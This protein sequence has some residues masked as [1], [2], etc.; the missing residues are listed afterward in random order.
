MLKTTG[1]WL[2]W[3]KQALRLIDPDGMEA[4]VLMAHCT[5]R[6]RA[7]L[8]AR[9]DMVL[10]A[11]VAGQYVADVEARAEG[12]PVAYITGSREFWSLEFE[13]SESVLIPRHETELVVERAL[14]HLANQARGRAQVVDLGTGSGVIA[15]AVASECESCE[16]VAV[17]RSRSA[18]R[19]ARRNQKRL[20]LS[21]VRFIQ[22]S[23]FEAFDE[24]ETRFDLVLSNPPYIDARDDHLQRGD[25][26]FEPVSALVAAD[27][28][29]AD[30]R[31]IIT[32]GKQYLGAGGWMVLEHGHTQ[33][34]VIQDCF[35]KSG[36]ESII[37]HRDL[38]GNSRVTEARRPA[39]SV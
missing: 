32:Q 5:G 31:A 2:S 22:G 1:E 21:N 35:L 26:R 29:L 39:I 25:L 9:D 14:V 16:V 30:I 10:E 8:Y 7:S 37:T 18:I 28:G 24:D 12:K 20:G 11:E 17:D 4:M 33:G 15:L 36:Y 27:N 3:G 34:P 38:A 13:V 19:V 23:W 6:S